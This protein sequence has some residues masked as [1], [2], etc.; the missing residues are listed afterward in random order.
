MINLALIDDDVKIASRLHGWLS[1]KPEVFSEGHFQTVNGLLESK[2]ELE[3]L[4]IILL[5]I[6]LDG[7]N[8]ITQIGRIKEVFPN[9]QIII[10]SSHGGE[11][12]VFSALRA[13]AES[14]CL[15]GR[16]PENLW[17]AIKDTYEKGSYLDPLVAR[18]VTNYFSKKSE[19][20]PNRLLTDRELEVVQGLVDG[21]SYKLIAVRMGIALNTVR[22]FIK[23]IYKKLEINSKSEIIAK[24]YKGEIEGF[25]IG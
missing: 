7:T 18:K 25:K 22:H 15:K 13:G 2:S 9:V 24:A 23:V 19:K 3:E 8:G 14:Y 1:A 10:L 6:E 16:N 5:D 21:L 20:D 4:D 11:E 17:E 12:Y